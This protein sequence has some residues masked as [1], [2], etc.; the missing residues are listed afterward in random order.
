MYL[1][2]AC[3]RKVDLLNP[4]GLVGVAKEL[5]PKKLEGAMVATNPVAV[6]TALCIGTQWSKPGPGILTKLCVRE[7]EGI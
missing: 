4:V 5:G 7:G 6:G 1:H 3:L 2:Q